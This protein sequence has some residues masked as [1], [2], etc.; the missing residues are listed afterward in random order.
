M[1]ERFSDRVAVVT[2]GV[3]GIG[4]AITRRLVSEGARV[5]AVDINKELVDSAADTFG[6]GV[7]GHLADVTDERGFEEA[8]DRAA[9]E[10][11]PLDVL[12]N[13]AGGSRGAA[14]T[15][16][17]YEDW[18]FTIRLNLYSTFL[19]VRGAARR[20]IAAG[21]AGTIVN[22]ASLNA[23][24]PMHFGAGY[25]SSKAAV[26][27]LT[28]QAALELAEH[29]IRVNAVSPGLVATPLTAG[30]TQHRQAREAFLERIPLNRAAEPDEVAAAATFLAS[31]EA[32]YISG[33][34]LVI[35]GAWSTTGYPDLR[36]AFG[37]A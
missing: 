34:N 36:R 24:T 28:R 4:A 9:D 22:I 5:L 21:K 10:L 15:D 8:I 3:S 13:V 27:M 16:M 18:D 37:S 17:S 23:F 30:I 2:G 19:G 12:F 31:D 20:F 25:S 32:A 6:P 11:G 35:D 29:G 7:I 26:V 33:E 1:S 14:L